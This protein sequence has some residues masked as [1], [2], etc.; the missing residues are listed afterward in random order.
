MTDPT[1]D[2]TPP[3]PAPAPQPTFWG[4]V[5]GTL[6]SIGHW[7]ALKLAAP[8]VAVVIII[9]AILLVA[10]GF[11]ELQIGGLLAKLFG[12]PDPA[13][14]A[15]DVANSVPPG[16]VGPDGKIIPQG[17]PDSKGDTQAVVVPIQD[18]GL[19]S[20]PSTVIFTPPGSTTPVEIQLPDGIKNSDVD[21]VI[22]VKPDV[23]AVTVK[24]SSNIPAQKIDDLLAK[25]GG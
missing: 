25:Y 3:P 2:P 15:I 9:V 23:V 6:K 14:K 1:P 10:M 8:G 7:M 13:Q 20:N 11:K 21:K 19:F 12:K 4:A 22:V 24:D 17:T 5:W 16:R 18:P